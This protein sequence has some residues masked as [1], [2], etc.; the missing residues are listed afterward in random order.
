MK[1]LLT[2]FCF[3]FCIQPAFSQCKV[4]QVVAKGKEEI[5]PGYLYDGFSLSNFDLDEKRKRIQVKFVAIKGQQY[6]IYFCN[7]GFTEEVKVSA[8]FEEKDGTLSKDLLGATTARD[9]LI[10]LALNKSGNYIFEYQTPVFEDVEFGAKK[11]ECIVS[12][13][14]YKLK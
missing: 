10:E 7:S 2:L 4:A 14:T 13:I 11:N 5:Q 1:K 6:K 9:E 3:L 12:L 8:Y